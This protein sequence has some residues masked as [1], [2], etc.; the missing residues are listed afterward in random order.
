M[1]NINSFAQNL[2]N[3]TSNANDAME[4][5]NKF[6]ESMVTDSDSI[7]VSLSSG[8]VVIPS[9]NSVINK[10]QRAENT[11]SALTNGSGYVETAD[12]TYRKL[13]VSAV[14]IP[15]AKITGLDDASIFYTDSNWFFEDM[16]FPKIDISVNL[17]D[18][19]DDTADRVRV[20]RVILDITESYGVNS[21][22]GSFF[23]SNVQSKTLSYPALISLLTQ[24][25]I[26]YSE[27]DEVIELPLTYEKYMGQFE[28][29]KVTII[30]GSEWY[31]IDGINYGLLDDNGTMVTNN[32][33]LGV[34]DQL[35]YN[36]S[37]FTISEIDKTAKRIRITAQLGYD[38]P[39]VGSYFHFYN[40]PFKSKTVKIGIGYNEANSIYI[41]GVNENYNILSSEWSEPINFITNDLVSSTDGTTT[42]KEYYLS[43]VADFGNLLISSI[44]EG[45]VS[46]YNGI[47][48]NAPVL[49]ANDLQVVQIN[50]QINSALSDKNVTST[51]SQIETAKSNISSIKT[52]INALK[53]DAV[54]ETDATKKAAIQTQIDSYTSQLNTTTSE[55][56]TL[57]K[58]LS[59][60]LYETG[61][62]DYSPKY[63]VRGFFNIPS[64]KY[65]DPDNLVGM[66]QVIG[67]DIMYRYIR[68]DD[69]GVS[70]NTFKYTDASTSETTSGIF[71][72]WNMVTTSILQKEYDSTTDT[73]K[74]V[75]EKVSD[76]NVININQVDI[77][78]TE[79]EKV[80]IKIRSI[81]EAGYPSN[82]L[83]SQWSNSVTMEFPDNLT[84]NNDL[85]SFIEEVQNE[86][87]AVLLS[88]T[89][90]SSGLYNHISD[91]TTNY[92]HNAD[93]IA[94]VIDG[95]TQS[96]GSVIRSI[97]GNN[98]I[99]I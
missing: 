97:L 78:I 11:V 93:N 63:R 31:Y 71:S 37:I 91:D 45:K 3:V 41:K 2:S 80:E 36:D 43:N 38:S 51:A 18:K 66:Q 74:W 60:L 6:S 56:N 53:D 17:K 83:K 26:G 54:S 1:A 32:Y 98:P 52:T 49:N 7:T 95:K 9:Y 86:N 92:H 14:P 82:P 42:L 20:K 85:T 87:T 73:F 34:G 50:T 30:N 68:L 67:F 96:L 88:E 94:I 28:I 65:T 5:L 55:Y 27:D 10:V 13:S 70:L 48:P 23:S 44:K 62:I 58:Y 46:A 90:K 39:A 89:L 79:G 12:G 99:T 35:R 16:M 8:D 61:A 72:D 21:T 57:V 81:S 15:P 25:G 29:T 69:T 75:E 4:I 33:E 22:V 59:G 64:P 76:G 40:E 84:S 19:I 47:T 77:P 24:Y